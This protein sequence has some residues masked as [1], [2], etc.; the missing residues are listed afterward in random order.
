M[1]NFYYAAIY[2]VIHEPFKYTQKMSTLKKL[3]AKIVHLNSTF[4]QKLMVDTGEQDKMSGEDPSLHHLIKTRKQQASRTIRQICDDQGIT[5][6]ESMDIMKVFTMH[7][8]KKICPIRMD[9]GSARLL[10]NFELRTV[11]HE[12]NSVME[13]PSHWTS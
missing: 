5:H 11:T 4:R 13:E 8:R 2:D 12:M 9:E 6:T 10:M 1:E 7:F 3:K